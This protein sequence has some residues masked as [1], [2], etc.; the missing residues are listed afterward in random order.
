MY[1]DKPTLSYD[2][3]IEK[4]KDFSEIMYYVPRATQIGFFSPFPSAI[5]KSDI[6]VGTTIG[7]VEM[8]VKIFFIWVFSTYLKAF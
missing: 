7:A 2:L 5:F 4:F 3:N 1:G 6:S 8:L